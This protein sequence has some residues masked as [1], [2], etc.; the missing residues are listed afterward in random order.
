M[1]KCKYGSSQPRNMKC[2]WE[3][4]MHVCIW[5]MMQK[6]TSLLLQTEVNLRREKHTRQGSTIQRVWSNASNITQPAHKKNSLTQRLWEFGILG[7]KNQ[8]VE[9]KFLNIFTPSFV[10]LLNIQHALIMKNGA[11]GKSK[12]RCFIYV[13]YAEVSLIMHLINTASNL[14]PRTSLFVRYSEGG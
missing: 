9:R 10:E 3:R 11:C 7:E 14:A 8:M 12:D 6:E 2:N 4:Q 5:N 1:H 13:K